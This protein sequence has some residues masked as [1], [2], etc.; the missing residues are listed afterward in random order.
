VVENF[1]VF[2]NM[3]ND[4]IFALI[5]LGF[6]FVLLVQYIYINEREFEKRKKQREDEKKRKENNRD[7]T[8]ES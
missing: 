4:A 6:L 1:F 2:I 8:K 5:V 3:T 7:F